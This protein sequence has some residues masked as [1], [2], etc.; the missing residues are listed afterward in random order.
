MA[1]KELRSLFPARVFSARIGNHSDLVPGFIHLQWSSK[2]VEG[3]TSALKWTVEESKE[4]K[5]VPGFSISK[6]MLK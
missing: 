1:G 5:G 3:S 4:R 2:E 6:L